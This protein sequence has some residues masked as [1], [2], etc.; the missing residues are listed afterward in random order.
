MPKELRGRPE[1]PTEASQVARAGRAR[2]GQQ[3]FRRKVDFWVLRF[4]T[5]AAGDYGA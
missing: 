5:A 1:F 2:C 4:F 3:T